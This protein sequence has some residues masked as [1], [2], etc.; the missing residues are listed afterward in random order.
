[1][2]G[3]LHVEHVPR[4][5]VYRVTQPF[6]AIQSENGRFLTV[7]R[8]SIITLHVPL[9]RFGLVEAICAEQKVLV[10]TG[11]IEKCAERVVHKHASETI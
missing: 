5:A 7:R 3:N 10:F 1:M 2:Q 8:G 4:A 6:A 11:D 9:E